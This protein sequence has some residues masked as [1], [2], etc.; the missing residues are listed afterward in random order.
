M[1]HNNLEF[2]NIF[3]KVTFTTSKVVLSSRVT[4]Q[5]KKEVNITKSLNFGGDRV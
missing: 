4:E 3:E 5:L 2:S 1:G